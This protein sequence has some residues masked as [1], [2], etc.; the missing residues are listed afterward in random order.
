M[1]ALPEKC[2]NV[3]YLQIVNDFFESC[4]INITTQTNVRNLGINYNWRIY[5]IRNKTLVFL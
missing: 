4:F 5:H 1:R 2:W 3:V